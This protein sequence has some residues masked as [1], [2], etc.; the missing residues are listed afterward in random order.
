MD[1]CLFFVQRMPNSQS[2]EDRE[3][4]VFEG[5]SETDYSSSIDTPFPSRSFSSSHL[6]PSLPP[7]FSQSEIDDSM[8]TETL[9]TSC[10][11]ASAVSDDMSRDVHMNF[12]TEDDEV[13]SP[14]EE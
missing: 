7:T 11:D 5:A 2:I 9:T 3:L 10:S 13:P 14:D 1:I 8:K 4:R 6:P 12:A